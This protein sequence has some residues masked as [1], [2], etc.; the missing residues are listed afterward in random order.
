MLKKGKRTGISGGERNITF[1]ATFRFPE[2][3][4]RAHW[5][6]MTTDSPEQGGKKKKNAIIPEQV[7]TFLPPEGGGEGIIKYGFWALR[8]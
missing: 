7:Y 5:V 6:R 2:R 4:K 8:Y 1:T 3:K